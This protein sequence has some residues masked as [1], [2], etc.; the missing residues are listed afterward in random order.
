VVCPS[1]FLWGIPCWDFV[2]LICQM[3]NFCM[4]LQFFLLTSFIYLWFMLC[5][6]FRF[7]LVLFKNEVEYSV[8]SNELQLKW[9][10]LPLLEQVEGEVVGSRPFYVWL[11][12]CMCDLRKKIIEWV[13]VLLLN[14]Y[15]S[16]KEGIYINQHSLLL[17]PLLLNEQ[18]WKHF[19]STKKTF[20]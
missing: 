16:Y 3:E 14:L 10:L 19:Y 17:L 9:K 11:T 1:N 15:L 20:D 13:F 6:H 4:L 18:K 2:V 7:W 12:W 5:I 8:V